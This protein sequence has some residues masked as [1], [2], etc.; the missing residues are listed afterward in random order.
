MGVWGVAILSND[1][2]EDIKFIYKDLL[3]DGYSNEEA[4]QVII[5][6]FLN[7]LDAEEISIF[8]LSFAL[9]QWKLGRLQE[10][11]KNKALEIIDSG[12]ELENWNEDLKLKKKRET[13]LLKLKQQLNLPQPVAKKIPKR[14]VADTTFKAGDAISYQLAS[15]DYIILKVIDIIEEWI[16]DR[17]PLFEICDWYGKVIPS[18]DEISKLSIKSHSSDEEKQRPQKI[19]VYPFSKMDMAMKRASLIAENIPVKSDNQPPYTLLS[20]KELDEYIGDIR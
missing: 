12:V 11:V 2:A 10:N 3:G 5:Q 1:I 4:S 7:E 15:A 9:I 16:G 20:W 17:Y 18:K 19:A 14:F 13:V 6:E 8:W